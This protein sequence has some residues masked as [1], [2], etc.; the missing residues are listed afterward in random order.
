MEICLQE[1]EESLKEALEKEKRKKK[2]VNYCWD[3]DFGSALTMEIRKTYEKLHFID[4][5][6]K[7]S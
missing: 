7:P 5:E 3:L 4:Y 2:A 1:K 6:E